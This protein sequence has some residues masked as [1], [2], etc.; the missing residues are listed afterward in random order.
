MSY[1]KRPGPADVR[2]RE[3][4]PMSLWRRYLPGLDSLL[5]YRREWLSHDIVAGAVLAAVIVPVGMAYAEL[6]GL[7]PVVGL[8]ASLVPLLAYVVFG[9][10]R[11]L[12]VGPDSTTAPLVA[13]AI[14]PLAGAD[15]AERIALGGMLALMVGALALFVGLARLGFVT[16]LLSR[17]VR[18]GYMNGVALIIIVS[19]LPKLFG[20]KGDGDGVVAQVVWFGTHL[21]TANLVALGFGL[22][23]LALILTLRLIAPKVPGV[24]VAAVLA[25]V[26]SAALGLGARFGVPTVGAMP[27]GLPFPRWPSVPL[28][29]VGA[30]FA[31]AM[32]IAV[33]TLTD[34]TV[35]SRVFA[36]RLHYSA[37]TDQELTAIGVTNLAAGL[38][39]GF[40]VSGSQTR[41]AVSVEAGAKSQG[42][43][44]AGAVMLAVLLVAA[45]WLL[46]TLPISVLAA[47]VI[48]AGI[49]LADVRGTVK[50]M[51]IRRTE[52]GLSIAAFLGVAFLGVLPGVFLAVALSL[53]NFVRR[54]WRPHDAVLGRA[55][56]VKGYHDIGDF[57][58]AQQVPGLLLFRFDA[59]LFFANGEMF[60]RRVL[61]LVEAADPPVKRVVIAAEPIT[62]VDTTAIDPLGRLVD[63]L[64]DQGVEF[65][66]A[67]LKHPVREHLED[68]GFIEKLGQDRLYPTLGSAV[69]AFVRDHGADWVD[70][71][72]AEEAEGA[73]DP[74][75]E[76]GRDSGS[77]G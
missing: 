16:E 4:V 59:P 13:A 21:S 27:Q 30:L 28:G 74:G 71:E 53:L 44:L 50:L 15:V 69:H 48:V 2:S 24:L 49:S 25:G 23:T 42:A 12:T 43:A 22:G 34:T 36:A 64:A 58:E 20:F 31:A 57:T 9:P 5:H 65:G 11:V 32:G 35:M 38:F 63:D 10:S 55:P 46:E 26:I 70:W 75:V 60:R 67:E 40:P 33:I 41:T 61:D 19:Q 37:D 47:I 45:P 76:A 7:P 14:I 52:F 6:A 66:F 56:G 77:R 39:Q 8:Y 62:D 3:E 1:P 68:Y 72:D 51:R 54:L 17:P 73:Q 29:E 18:V